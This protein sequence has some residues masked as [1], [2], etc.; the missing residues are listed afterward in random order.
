M[1]TEFDEKTLKVI[2]ESFGAGERISNE[3]ESFFNAS[4]RFEKADPAW[5]YVKGY[6]RNR[7]TISFE[8]RLKKMKETQANRSTM[9]SIWK[10]LRALMTKIT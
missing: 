3:Q 4:F 5:I 2:A 10:K 8:A 1:P 9:P 7:K 6:R